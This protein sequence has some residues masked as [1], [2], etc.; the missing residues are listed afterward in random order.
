MKNEKEANRLAHLIIE[1][2]V[3]VD[4]DIVR[5]IKR[6]MRLY[7]QHKKQQDNI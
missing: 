3:K 7:L 1:K 5:A 4:S 2:P 6:E